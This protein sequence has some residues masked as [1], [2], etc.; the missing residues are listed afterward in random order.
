VRY[1]R[2]HTHPSNVGAEETKINQ[3]GNA[4]LLQAASVSLHGLHGQH[5]ENVHL[6]E[7]NSEADFWERLYPGPY[8][9]LLEKA[10]EFLKK[11]EGEAIVFIRYVKRDS[12]IDGSSEPEPNSQCWI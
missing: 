2:F 12:C 4:A 7:Y 9:R 10:E 6:S 1:Q 5:I 11:G 8:S 3:D